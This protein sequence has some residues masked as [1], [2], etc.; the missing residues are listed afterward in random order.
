MVGSV[1]ALRIVQRAAAA[2][3]S[4]TAQ[5]ATIAFAVTP[6]KGNL[7]IQ[8]FTYIATFQN[9][10]FPAGFTDITDEVTSGNLRC[11]CAWAVADG[12]TNSFQASTAVSGTIK[13]MTMA[14][15]IEGWKTVPAAVGKSVA[16]STSSTS[17]ACHTASISAA[18]GDIIIGFMNNSNTSST[19][20]ILPTG[21]ELR[22]TTR[23]R[24]AA[25]ADKK[26]TAALSEVPTFS[27]VTGRS[28]NA[29][30]IKI[31]A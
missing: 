17:I 20:N 8:F 9:Y 4:D 30:A 27:W 1:P 7:I 31:A 18:V 11:A 29:I 22:S 23:N 19:I 10:A 12:V 28:A 21:Y 14:V 26:Y 5:N 15:E 25:M 6:T 24:I 3:A 13:V 16:S 2:G